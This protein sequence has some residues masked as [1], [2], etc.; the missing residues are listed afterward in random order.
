MPIFLPVWGVNIFL[1]GSYSK[2]QTPFLSYILRNKG[3]TFH[4]SSSEKLSDSLSSIETCKGCISQQGPE[5]LGSGWN[6]KWDVFPCRSLV[7]PTT[8]WQEISDAACN[9]TMRQDSESCSDR[10]QVNK[11]PI[12]V[13]LLDFRVFLFWNPHGL[14]DKNGY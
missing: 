8:S 4:L 11:R 13:D 2:F 5:G 12:R 10:L 6:R 9:L 1:T 14:S 7:S 3:K